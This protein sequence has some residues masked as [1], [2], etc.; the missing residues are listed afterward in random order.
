MDYIS[1]DIPQ[2]FVKKFGKVISNEFSSD[3]ILP[4]QSL[5]YLLHCLMSLAYFKKDK[6]SINALIER[7]HKNA[8][9]ES[10]A[11][12]KLENKNDV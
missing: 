6:E 4:I 12:E 9:D 7:A 5:Y 10:I 11:L 8:Y 2:D 1:E 3:G